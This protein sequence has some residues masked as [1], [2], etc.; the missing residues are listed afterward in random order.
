MS[1]VV[2]A[3]Y[4]RLVGD[5]QLVALLGTYRDAPC[6]FTGQHIPGEAPRPLVHSPGEFGAG[7][8]TKDHA[9]RRV[10][11]DVFVY[12]DGTGSAKTIDTIAERVYSILH[13]QSLTVES[14]TNWLILASPPGVAPT[15]D[16]L[17]GR[18]VTLTI[19]LIS[20]E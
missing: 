14:N 17:Q 12:A 1:L 8:D 9:G 15:D 6:V 18:V 20:E 2:P 16:T 19:G 13:R 11:R 10:V 7:D 3:L 4:A 5:A